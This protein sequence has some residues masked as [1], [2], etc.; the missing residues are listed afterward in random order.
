MT[1]FIRFEWNILHLDVPRSRR[2]LGCLQVARGRLCWQVRLEGETRL[3]VPKVTRLNFCFCSWPIP[4]SGPNWPDP[5][6]NLLW[7]SN[8]TGF[9]MEKLHLHPSHAPILL[10]VAHPALIIRISWLAVASTHQNHQICCQKS[11]ADAI[12]CKCF[13]EMASCFQWNKSQTSGFIWLIFVD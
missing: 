5:N 12:V 8:L 2:L 4:Q 3:N 10:P 11:V 1:T 7:Q 6:G 9:R 13:A